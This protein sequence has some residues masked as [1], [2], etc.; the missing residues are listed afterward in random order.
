MLSLIDV[1]YKDKHNNFRCLI[2]PI[3]GYLFPGQDKIS[4]VTHKLIAK[5][6][7]GHD[8]DHTDIKYILLKGKRYIFTST[9]NNNYICMFEI[10]KTQDKTVIKIY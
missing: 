3:F 10:D 7:R 9:M 1:V 6:E 4:I 2:K 5:S 8:Y